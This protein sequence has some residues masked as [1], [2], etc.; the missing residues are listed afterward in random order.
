VHLHI[1]D[2]VLPP[3]VWAPALVASLLLL[4]VSARTRAGGSRQHVAYQGALGALTLAAMAIELPLGPLEY[5]LTL[6]GPIGVLLGPPAAFEV[7]FVVNAILAML[8]H[9]G[10][11][12]VGLNALVLG[13]GAALARPA[14]A[15]FARRFS[16][17]TS[18]A[19]ATSVAQAASGALWLAAIGYALHGAA[20]TAGQ[21]AAASRLGLVAGLAFPMWLVGI[22]VES[23]VAVGI[24]RFLARV[25]PDLLPGSRMPSAGAT[26][27]RPGNEEA[28]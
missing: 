5:H 17:G 19:L 20:T 28:A 8:G 23:V 18:L 11:T 26:G 16:P 27:P 15:A 2:G 14:Y 3:W 25:R 7:L 21:P 6:I 1:P 9:G 10:F 22:A 12:V 13:A 4:V 24:G